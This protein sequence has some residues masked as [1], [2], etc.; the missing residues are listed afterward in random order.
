[1]NIKIIYT[2]YFSD[3]KLW[4]TKNFINIEDALKILNLNNLEKLQC[5]KKFNSL[6]NQDLYAFK[7][8]KRIKI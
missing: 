7:E 2:D 5:K 3:A 8:V 4:Y 6:K 1:M